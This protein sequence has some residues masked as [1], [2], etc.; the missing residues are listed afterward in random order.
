[1]LISHLLIYYYY[2]VAW[3]AQGWRYNISANHSYSLATTTRIPDMTNGMHTVRIRYEPVFDHQ[4]ILHPSFQANGYSSWF[5][6]VIDLYSLLFPAPSNNDRCISEIDLSFPNISLHI[7]IF[8][9]T[10]C[11][12]CT[13]I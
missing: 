6:E 10:Y 1:M 13:L 2:F 7:Q 11:I 4:A 9:F 5:L 12:L 8:E 3:D